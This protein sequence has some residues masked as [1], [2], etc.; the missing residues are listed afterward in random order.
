MPILGVTAIEK[1]SKIN[2]ALDNYW[3]NV[4]EEAGRDPDIELPRR[5]GAGVDKHR[6]AQHRHNKGGGRGR[7]SPTLRGGSPTLHDPNEN[8][9]MSRM[10]CAVIGV[11]RTDPNLRYE[12]EVVNSERL[13]R[14]CH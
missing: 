3:R 8:F 5:S 4:Y 12:V 10:S 2:V 1:M 7:P 6:H 9:R 11:S 14:S 13:R